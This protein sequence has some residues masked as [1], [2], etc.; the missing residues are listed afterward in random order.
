MESL[1]ESEIEVLLWGKG[2]AKKY[3][4][5]LAGEALSLRFHSVERFLRCFRCPFF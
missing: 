5:Y 1:L 4:P 3:L 2:N